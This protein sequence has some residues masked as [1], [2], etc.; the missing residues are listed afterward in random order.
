MDLWTSASIATV[1]DTGAEV[2]L[3]AR[4]AQW[5]AAMVA[6]RFIIQS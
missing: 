6:L 4:G 5:P 3:L 2:L 1:I